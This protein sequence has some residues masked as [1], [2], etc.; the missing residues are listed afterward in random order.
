MSPDP[1]LLRIEF[2][3]LTVRHDD[4]EMPREDLAGFFSQVS[5]R[6][7][8]QRFE[9]HSDAGAT[10]SSHDGS[11][12]VLRPT[13]IASCGVTG[14]CYLE[15]AERVIGLVGEAVDRYGIGEL[16]VEDITIVAVWDVGDADAARALLV[17]NVLQIDEDRLDLLQGDEISLGLRIWRRRGEASLECAVEPMHSEPSKVYIRLV[18]TSSEG[19]PDVAALREAADA[20]HEFLLGP[21]AAF[22]MARARR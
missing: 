17:E 18:Q 19:L 15:G 21:L 10:L 8:L 16:W 11:E 6:Y 3:G 1:A 5:D 7:G 14:L 4:V 13:H 9:Y 20:V 2:L 12:C 22:M